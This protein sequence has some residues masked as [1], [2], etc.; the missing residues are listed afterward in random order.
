MSDEYYKSFIDYLK[1]NNIS[2][3]ATIEILE[4]A[5][6]AG[7]TAGYEKFKHICWNEQNQK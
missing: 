2:D 7:Y 3:P 4:S 6:Q 5:Y 1:Q